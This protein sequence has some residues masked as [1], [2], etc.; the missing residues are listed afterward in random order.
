MIHIKVQ[1][2][3]ENRTLALVDE[4]DRIFLDGDALYDLVVPLYFEKV[5]TD[6]I[7]H[8]SPVGSC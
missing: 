7:E 2:D 3:A 1:Y 8:L 5:G 4:E 6:V